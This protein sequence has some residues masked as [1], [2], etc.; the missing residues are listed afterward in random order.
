[1]RN[2]AIVQKMYGHTAKLLDYCSGYTYETF[3]AD[4]KLVEACV[5]NLSQL[6][7][8]C[9]AVDDAF[10]QK[11]PEIPWREIYGLRNRIVHDY[12]GVNLRLVWE[13]ISEDIPT[14]KDTLQNLID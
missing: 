10:A 4:M 7:E 5:F 12:E 8:L 6:G 2:K 1:M 14:L 9:H 3:I 13:I 11:H